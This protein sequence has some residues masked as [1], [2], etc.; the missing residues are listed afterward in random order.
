ML[1]G[2]ACAKGIRI[3]FVIREG[4]GNITTGVDENLKKGIGVLLIIP[5]DWERH[6]PLIE[7]R[8]CGFSTSSC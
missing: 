6:A 7:L 1:D 8:N 5:I 3:Y 2:R 4:T